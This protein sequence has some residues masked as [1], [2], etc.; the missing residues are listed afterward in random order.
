[1]EGTRHNV[2]A[3][4]LD[5]KIVEQSNRYCAISKKQKE[6]MKSINERKAVL[7]E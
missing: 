3:D 7:K 1:L 4:E 5:L 6:N 2:V